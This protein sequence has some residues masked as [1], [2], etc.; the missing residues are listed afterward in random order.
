MGIKTQAVDL[1]NRRL[2]ISHTVVK[3]TTVHDED[4]VK[5]QD[6]LR[7]FYITDEMLE[8]FQRVV[9]KKEEARAFYGNTYHESKSQFTWEDGKAF[10]PDYLEPQLINGMW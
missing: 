2:T 7:E 9:K 1:K 6:S 10:S 3:I 5:S 4:N 8:F